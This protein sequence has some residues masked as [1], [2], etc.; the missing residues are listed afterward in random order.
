MLME[1]ML[2]ICKNGEL[3]LTVFLYRKLDFKDLKIN[4][5]KG[6]EASQEEEK[7]EEKALEGDKGEKKESTNV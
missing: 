1:K 7:K 2:M 6:V 5:K 3:D 4:K